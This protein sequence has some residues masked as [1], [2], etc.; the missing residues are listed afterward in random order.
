MVGT[1]VHFSDTPGSPA[2]VAPEIGQHT[3]EVLLE[4]GF[5]WDD[6]GRLRAEGAV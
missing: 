6:I 1:P 2:W 4:L 3:E 5:T